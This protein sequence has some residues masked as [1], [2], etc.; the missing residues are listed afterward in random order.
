MIIFPAIDIKDKNCVRLYKGDFNTVQKVAEDPVKTAR[1]F[2]SAG[3][4]YLHMV[5]LDGAVLAKPENADVFLE[6]AAQTDMFIEL[7]GGIRTLETA[8]FYLKNGIS[9]VILGSAAV[10][11]PGLVKT[12]VSEFGDRIAVGIDAKDGMAACEGWLSVEKIDYI[13]LAKQMYDAGVKN[14]IFTDISKDG[15]LTGPN[16]VQLD[17]INKAVGA[18]ITASGGIHNIDDIKKLKQLG[19]Y[20]AICGKS[21]Y[22]GALDLHEALC[23]ATGK[24]SAEDR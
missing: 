8:E 12:A 19:M 2:Y 5:D 14:I 4:R 23:C 22:S 11:N 18:N 21:L 3:A 1:D 20:A 17:A 10:K 6:V 15:T 9:R 24:T 16:F 13:T 7:G